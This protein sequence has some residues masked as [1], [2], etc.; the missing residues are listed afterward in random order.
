MATRTA[1]RFA[2][3]KTLQN[4]PD[5]EGRGIIADI[6]GEM[7]G[8]CDVPVKSRPPLTHYYGGCHGD[9]SSPYQNHL[10]CNFAQSFCGFAAGAGTDF[11]AR[12]GENLGLGAGIGAKWVAG[13]VA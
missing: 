13:A 4:V 1:A 10:T 5:D 3:L 11:L 9:M 8:N 12:C 6:V 7:V 2:A